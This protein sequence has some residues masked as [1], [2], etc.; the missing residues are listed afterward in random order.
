M[1]APTCNDAADD[2]AEEVKSSALRTTT[3]YGFRPNTLSQKSWLPGASP[4]PLAIEENGGKGFETRQTKW[5]GLLSSCAVG[6]PTACLPTRL[7]QSLLRCLMTP[8]A[9]FASKSSQAE[10]CPVY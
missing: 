10:T 4:W 2:R 8:P 6:T 1:I 3:N 7:A 9:I 5:S